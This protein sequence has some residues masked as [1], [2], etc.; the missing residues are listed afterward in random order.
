[1]R[2]TSRNR[3][4]PGSIETPA[5][6]AH[7]AQALAAACPHMAAA[8]EACGGPPPLRRRPPGFKTLARILIGQQ[9]SVAS[10]AAIWRRLERG[11]G[12][13]TPAAV[14]AQGD[15][16]LRA[17]GL[18]RPKQRYLRACARAVDEGTLDLAG[19]HALDDAAARVQL[20]QVTGI[21]PWTADIYLLSGLGRPDVFPAGDLA[22][23]VAAQRLMRKR[24]RPDAEGLARLARRWRPWRGLAARILWS[25][26]SA[27]P[28]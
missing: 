4:A 26:H 25:Y 13:V 24:K 28:A 9:L 1:M 18:S 7:A 17:M 6:I 5:D 21:G 19:L 15:E 23:Q 11:L 10:A 20:L 27:P 2:T 14:L 8:L 16:D 12:A 3:A 22:L